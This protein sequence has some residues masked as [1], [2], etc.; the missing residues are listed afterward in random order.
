L[1]GHFEG[2]VSLD[3]LLSSL[4]NAVEFY[5]IMEIDDA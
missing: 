2:R 1:I 3:I 4:Y 5:Y